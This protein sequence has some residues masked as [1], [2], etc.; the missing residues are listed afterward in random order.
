MSDP[1]NDDQN[2]PSSR[3]CFLKRSSI[4]AAGTVIASSLSF[5]RSV[6]AGGNDVLK[7]GLV[8]CGGRG[9]GAAAEALTGDKNTKLVAMGDTFADR[10]TGSLTNLTTDPA[11]SAQIDVPTER[12]FVGFDAY[13]NVIDSG[14]DVVLLCG[15]PGFRP[16]HFKYAVEKNKHV[17][18]EKPV[19]V[20]GPGIRTIF[21]AAQEAKKK[22]LAV[23]SGFCYRY[24]VP[25]REMVKRIHD[26]EI[27][28][29][30]SL[31]VSSNKGASWHN[32]QKPEWSEMEYQI[33]NWYYF[34]WLSGDFNVE[35]H[36]HNID[37]AAWVM[38]DEPPIRATG[39]GGRQVRT[40]EQFGHIY[41]HM[42]VVYEFKNGTRLY[43]N[44][45]QING[46]S[47]DTSDLIFGTKGTI[48]LARGPVGPGR[49]RQKKVEYSGPTM[50]QQEQ[51]ELF[52]SIRNGTPINDG[53]TMCKSTMMA[54]MGRMAC[55]T[56][57]SLE[58][59]QCWN[60]KEDL[61]PTKLE[62]GPIATPPVAM[63]GITEFV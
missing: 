34:T 25:M 38:H 35:K 17:F 21:A 29:V 13:K 61:M 18:A 63:P 57:Q 56:G 3:R 40:G 32:G 24:N 45:R 55:Y 27:G 37:K 41:D 31:Q 8:G 44:C 47:N 60:S 7:V 26:G 52:A 9:T 1:F 46:C 59:D 16:T 14:V 11:L 30:V 51:T 6:H 15:P 19:A 2:S 33:R 58:W 49:R 54:I 36:V 43:S 50:W 42:S 48:E 39:L 62:W 20:D 53:D 28:D 5:P 10:L 23:V 22:G 4:I 12:Q